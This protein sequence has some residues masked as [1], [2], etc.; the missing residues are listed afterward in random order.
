M[1]IFSAEL[2]LVGMA[3]ISAAC[4]L[5]G[6]VSGDGDIAVFCQA[7]GI[8]ARD[9]FLY[10][11]IGMGNDYGRI[12]AVSFI[13]GRSVDIGRY[14]Y[15]VQIIVYR[16]ICTFPGAFS[17]MASAYTSPKGLSEA[18]YTGSAMARRDARIEDMAAFLSIFIS[19]NFY[20]M[21]GFLPE[22]PKRDQPGLCPHCRQE[23]LHTHAVGLA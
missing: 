4:A 9:L 10:A 8:K 5:V 12:R 16:G 22:F 7:L 20:G 1:N 21:Q 19:F 14:F 15:A 18:A 23:S 13:V 11:A 17:R 3:W 6:C 2:G